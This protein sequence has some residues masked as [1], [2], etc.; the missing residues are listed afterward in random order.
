M[1]TW[2]PTQYLKFSDYRTRP[3]MEL[4]A[5]IPLDS[6]KRAVDL[7]CGPGNSTELLAQR[8]PDAFIRG[9]DNSKDML[10]VARRAHPDW[11]WEES[12]IAS[13]ISDEPQDLIFSNAA[14]H[15]LPLHGILL[16]RLAQQLSKGGVLAIQMPRNFRA[17]AHRLVRQIAEDGP[18]QGILAGVAEWHPPLEPAEYYDIL[19]SA[20]GAIDTIDTIDIWETEYVQIMDSTA[21]IAEWIKGSTLRPFLDKLS[22]AQQHQFLA[23]YTEVLQF[24]YPLQP[25]GRV[26]F[27]FKRIFIVAQ[28]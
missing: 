5:R 18:W 23:R 14:L 7:G 1:T 2:D 16:P 6:P 24:A 17:P 21:A 26:L 9:V 28:R 25:D 20:G 12:D 13:W 11:I 19:S 4:L 10:D 15:W 8:W 3:A 22:D 27:P